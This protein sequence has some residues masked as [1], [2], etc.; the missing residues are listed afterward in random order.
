VNL[1]LEF[2][3]VILH[4]MDRKG[5]KVTSPTLHRVIS[6]KRD[7]SQFLEEE[8]RHQNKTVKSSAP[9]FPLT[10]TNQAAVPSESNIS[11][12]PFEAHYVM[13]EDA[14][15]IHCPIFK[16]Y[17]T[18][19]LQSTSE[20]AFKVPR[21]AFPMF[22]W[23]SPIGQCPFIPPLA[24]QPSQAAKS[25]QSQ[26]QR[27]ASEKKENVAIAQE[28]ASTKIGVPEFVAG[29][30][31][32][33]ARMMKHSR[34]KQANPEVPVND[35]HR[36]DP[37]M[38]DSTIMTAKSVLFPAAKRGQAPAVGVNG[39]K[40][41]P[42]ISLNVNRATASTPKHP[43]LAVRAQSAKVKS[44]STPA[45]PEESSQT[46]KRKSAA[47]IQAHHRPRPGFCEC[48]Y[49]KYSDLEKVSKCKSWGLI[50]Y[51]FSMLKLITIARMQFRALIT[52]ESTSSWEH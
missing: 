1:L 44:S 46:K 43:I 18:Q 37:V 7:L 23:D 3:T 29:T 4:Y 52:R 28:K 27:A 19:P 13:I 45:V 14:E 50:T 31:E 9:Q 47:S 8:K 42:H 22:Y 32:L 15:G 25:L 36:F 17:A 11:F 39:I 2:A 26:N 12:L 30:A 5:T 34:M 33:R 35:I 24:A 41:T 16:E 40:I 49:E 20:Q 10:R 38:T 48:C 6:R 21:M 51:R